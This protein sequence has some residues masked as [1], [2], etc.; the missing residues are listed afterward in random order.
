M[1]VRL[2]YSDLLCVRI[3][4]A[5]DFLCILARTRLELALAAGGLHRLHEPE[6]GLLHRRERRLLL[7]LEL[8]VLLLELVDLV[9]ELLL[10]RGDLI[11]LLLDRLVKVRRRHRLQLLDLR[12]RLIVAKVELRRAAHRLQTLRELLERSEVAAT[13]VVL[14]VVRVAVLDRRVPSLHTDRKS[15]PAQFQVRYSSPL[16]CSA[17][18]TNPGNP[19][20]FELLQRPISLERLLPTRK[21]WS[22]SPESLPSV[23]THTDLVT[24]R[25]PT[26]RAVDVRNERR[27]MPIE[28]LNQLV[29]VRLH[30]LAVASPD[31]GTQHGLQNRLPR[32]DPECTHPPLSGGSR[33]KTRVSLKH[34]HQSSHR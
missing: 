15:F 11:I 6:A 29:P 12:L 19:I 24:K 10:R 9:G 14:Q 1:Q 7:V 2:S 13:L 8:L 4:H 34:A 32:I 31:P 20:C 17:N 22:I 28:L 21:S 25:L 26:R 23:P 3:S 30:L 33:S 27:G 16:A 18:T 5:A